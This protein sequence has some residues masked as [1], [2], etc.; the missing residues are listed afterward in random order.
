MQKL[1]QDAYK[2]YRYRWKQALLS[3]L[4]I[5]IA[6]IA[7]ILIQNVADMLLKATADRFKINGGYAMTLFLNDISGD[8]YAN[9][10]Q[11]ALLD[12]T[13]DYHLIAHDTLKVHDRSLHNSL[14]LLM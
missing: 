7:L 9:D 10:Y 13:H 12:T 4:G 1:I 2:Q 8:I 6:T 14:F 11:K 5:V 3:S